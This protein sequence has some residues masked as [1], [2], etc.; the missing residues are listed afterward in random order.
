MHHF[1]QLMAAEAKDGSEDSEM[2]PAVDADSNESNLQLI[3]EPDVAPTVI[4]NVHTA[5]FCMGNVTSGASLGNLQLDNITPE[6]K[7]FGALPGATGQADTVI[8]SN[9]GGQQ[10]VRKSFAFV[11]YISSAVSVSKQLHCS[12]NKGNSSS[13]EETYG[14]W[15]SV[16][17]T[18]YR[19]KAKS[20]SRIFK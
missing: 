19:K 8:P 6:T 7:S 12:G 16:R 14:F 4:T 13:I 20:I 18:L 15:C 1:V 2:I 11:C 10:Q 3:A 17:K 5:S 9:G